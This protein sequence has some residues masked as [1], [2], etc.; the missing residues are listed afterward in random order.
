MGGRTT[1]TTRSFRQTQH[2]H[3]RNTRKTVGE[4][5]KQMRFTIEVTDWRSA[6]NARAHTCALYGRVCVCVRKAVCGGAATPSDPSAKRASLELTPT[7]LCVRLASVRVCVFVRSRARRFIGD[8]RAL[9]MFRCVWRARASF[10]AMGGQERAIERESRARCTT[11]SSD[12]ELTR[13]CAAN[14]F[15]LALGLLTFDTTVVCLYVCERRAGVVHVRWCVC[16][17]S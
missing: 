8:A 5:R 7:R 3:T 10:F 2:T 1:R 6:A 4:F 9:H 14:M 12:E 15:L 16:L 11:G 13:V 17:C